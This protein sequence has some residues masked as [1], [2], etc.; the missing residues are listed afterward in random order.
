M[1]KFKYVLILAMA[2]LWALGGLST[3]Q[4]LTDRD[5][6]VTVNNPEFDIGTGPRV[7]ID[8][9]HHNF[10]TLNDRFWPFAALLRND[11]FRV[12]D[13]TLAFNAKELADFDILVVGNALNALNEINVGHW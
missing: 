10:H 8:S 12:A 4:V 5:A 7:A 2:G 9:A 3:T 13:R 11:G 1:P 6:D